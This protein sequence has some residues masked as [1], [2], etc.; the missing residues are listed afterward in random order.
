MS[1]AK[2]VQKRL[3]KYGIEPAVAAPVVLVLLLFIIL[4]SSPSSFFNILKA[5]F[6]LA[7][8]WLPVF[9]LPVFWWFWVSY[10]RSKFLLKQEYLLLEVRLG[11]EITR[12]PAAMEV[13]LLTLHNTGG[14][15][16]IINKYWE[17]KTRPQWSLEICAIEGKIRFFIRM[18]KNQRE[19]VEARLYAQYPD[20]EIVETDD[21]ARLYEY[22][23]NTMNLYGVEYRLTKPD[24]YPIKT[25]IDYGLDKLPEE[26]HKIDPLVPVIEFLGTCSPQENLWIQIMIRGRKGDQRKGWFSTTDQ[27]HDEAKAEI[28]K[29]VKG[30]D[31]S[32]LSTR[33][34]EVVT[35]I[36]RALT[37][38]SF[39]C[40]IRIIYFA[41]K[42]AY[43]G[44]TGGVI[45]NI[46]KSFASSDLN[47]FS[48]TRWLSGFDW[49]WQ[50][51]KGM[52]QARLK[53]EIFAMYRR[54]AYFYPPYAQTPF[55][56]NVEELATLYHF[57]GAI[58]QIPALERVGARKL[59]PPPNLPV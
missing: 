21:Y 7:P 15:T 47:G 28:S 25:Y 23:G 53:K 33:A 43:K 41:P 45:N 48:P 55:I 32:K 17:G 6:A 31:F 4:V 35:A 2:N 37:K 56:L 42:E 18:R 29:L 20:I 51:Y 46:F 26:E 5:L 22:D 44:G 19:L 30:G 50:D 59:S 40:G 9:A 39:E 49:P 38:P 34:Q 11:P 10:V 13:F 36:E 12:S 54:R 16:T 1:L 24:P 27:L 8:L 58:I 3:D 57:P 52:R 14:E